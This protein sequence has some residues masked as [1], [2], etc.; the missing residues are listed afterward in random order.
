[1]SAAVTASVALRRDG[2]AYRTVLH[3]KISVRI[4]VNATDLTHAACYC[5]HIADRQY[6]NSLANRIGLSCHLLVLVMPITA[7]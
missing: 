3:S 4:L 5:A 6:N 1:M 2:D 7:T